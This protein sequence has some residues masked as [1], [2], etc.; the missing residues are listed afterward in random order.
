MPNLPA[1]SNQTSLEP[2]RIQI[3]QI[4]ESPA[5][6]DHPVRG[7]LV[8][9]AHIP[10]IIKLVSKRCNHR[11]VRPLDRAGNRPGDPKEG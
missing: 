11:L 5:R 10:G 4:R 7:E 9:D 6:S 1:N 2:R 3:V 8:G